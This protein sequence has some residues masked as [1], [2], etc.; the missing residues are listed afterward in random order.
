MSTAR[1][2]AERYGK[3]VK[4]SAPISEFGEE[5]MEVRETKWFAGRHI[6]V[7][8]TV[9]VSCTAGVDRGGQV[10]GKDGD[11]RVDMSSVTKGGVRRLAPAGIDSEGSWFDRCGKLHFFLEL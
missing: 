5:Q 8:R 9:V 3:G 11:G 10:G 4:R 1:H 2:S 7:W 6:E